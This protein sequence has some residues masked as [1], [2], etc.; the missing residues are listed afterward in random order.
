MKNINLNEAKRLLELYKSI[1]LEQLNSME[2]NDPVVKLS[3]ITGFGS[4]LSCILCKSACDLSGEK[5][6]NII[7]R[8]QH[9]IYH[10]AYPNILKEL[11][12]GSY[13]V[14]CWEETYQAIEDSETEE[15]LYY[16]IQDRIEFLDKTIK[17]IENGRDNK[18][19]E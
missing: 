9:C 16:S 11:D 15:E 12:D 8:C 19:N 14:P 10:M 7:K 13:N 2:G 18:T 3:K 6:H 1:T 17:L 4:P 5:Y